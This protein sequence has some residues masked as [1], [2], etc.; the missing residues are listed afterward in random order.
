MIKKTLILSNP[1][2][3]VHVHRLVNEFDQLGH[4][5]AIFDPG[6]FPAKARF[7]A[8][9]C[10]DTR[11]SALVLADGTWIALEECGSVWYRRPT[12]IVPRDDLPHMEQTFIHREANVGIWGWL[13]GL[14][15]FWVNHP[16]AVRAAGQKP[17]QLQRAAAFG[18]AIP[19]S[20]V[21]NEPEAFQHFYEDCRGNVIYKLMGYPWYTDKSEAPISAFTSLVPCEMLEEAHRVAATAHLFQEFLVKRCDI[22]VTIIGKD[23]FATE[24]H[25]LSEQ[26]QI[27]FR[28]DYSKL[29]YAPHTLP[30]HLC[31]KLLA[32]TH[33]YHLAYASID[34]LLT[35]DGRYI[36]LELNPLG[37]FGWLE[38]CTG[39][40]LYRKL[41]TLLIEGGNT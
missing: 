10:D 35:Q 3:D 4:P 38:N 30:E 39:I 23:V 9:I 33:S 12:R 21:T 13:R 26:T 31:E 11:Q 2:D 16:D 7:H 37:Q 19:Q 24:I 25:P 34:L 28:A 1:T 18:L 20:I 32:L 5:W 36:Y 27:D 15:A 40:P 6:D 22:R 17:E 29:S 41:A 8:S 14:Q